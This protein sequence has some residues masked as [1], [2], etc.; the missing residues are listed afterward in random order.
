MS[1]DINAATVRIRKAGA[2]KVRVV[3]MA[4]QNVLT[5]KHQ[6]E[7]M[8]ND[9]WTPVATGMTKQIAESIVSTAVNKVICG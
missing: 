9:V 1:I 7:I 3:P 8:E 2:G 5:G 4:G 6:I